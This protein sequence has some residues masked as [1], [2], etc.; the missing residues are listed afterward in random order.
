VIDFLYLREYLGFLNQGCLKN[1]GKPLL[2][3]L[4][5]ECIISNLHPLILERDLDSQRYF[6]SDSSLNLHRVIFA[7]GTVHVWLPL[8]FL[9]IPVHFCIDKFSAFVTS[10]SFILA[11][12]I[13]LEDLKKTN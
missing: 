5:Q 9:V 4:G 2:C 7:L 8:T 11:F 12:P 10:K 1:L 13:S 3:C 6:W